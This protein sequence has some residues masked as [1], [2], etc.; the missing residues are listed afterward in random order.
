MVGIIF[1]SAKS[2]TTA[3]QRVNECHQQKQHHQGS[4]ILPLNNVQQQDEYIQ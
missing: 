3:I 1:S 2:E 4:D